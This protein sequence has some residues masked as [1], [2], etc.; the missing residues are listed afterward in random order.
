MSEI[1][2]TDAYPY[3]FIHQN[4]DN[5]DFEITFNKELQPGPPIN[6]RGDLEILSW[7]IFY[8]WYRYGVRPELNKSIEYNVF[9]K[10]VIKITPGIVTHVNF[11]NENIEWETIYEVLRN[12]NVFFN[13]YSYTANKVLN[14]KIYGD[15]T[16]I[17]RH[18]QPQKGVV[19]NYTYTVNYT[20]TNDDKATF[21]FTMDDTFDINTFN[22]RDYLEDIIVNW[23]PF[24]VD[25]YYSPLQIR[26]KCKRKT[27]NNT[28]TLK[29]PG[30]GINTKNL[31]FLLPRFEDIAKKIKSL[32]IFSNDMPTLEN[33]RD[34]VD[35]FW[36]MK[37]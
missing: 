27:E 19:K 6:H 23:Y 13:L 22:N 37:E 31:F 11:Q 29:M 35:D 2:E 12:L 25:I 17:I 18:G 33:M 15:L 5:I 7:Q 4:N 16:K 1:F 14:A 21:V 3:E 30:N 24:Y 9:L 36:K 32:D 20:R 28:F 8:L 10:N 34:C 26:K